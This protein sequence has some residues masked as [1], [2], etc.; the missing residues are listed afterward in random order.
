MWNVS[1]LLQA[2]DLSRM[3]KTTATFLLF[4]FIFRRACHS[5][6]GQNSNRNTMKNQN[7]L[8]VLKKEGH[9]TLLCIIK[10][11]PHEVLCWSF[12]KRVSIISGYF[13]TV[14][15]R[16]SDNISA[17]FGNKVK[18]GSPKYSINGLYHHYCPRYYYIIRY[19]TD[20]IA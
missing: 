4:I 18:C 10:C 14:F 1:S 7:N 2:T 3:Q 16:N 12:F 11:G 5:N 20:I 17:Q 13:T 8:I 19:C 15:S 6:K 9:F